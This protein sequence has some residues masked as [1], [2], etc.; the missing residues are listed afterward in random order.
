MSNPP[1]QCL[2][3]D[4]SRFVRTTEL[5]QQIRPA[6]QD[7]QILRCRRC[8]LAQLHPLPTADEVAAVYENSDYVHAYDAAGEQFVLSGDDAS[9]VLA[10]RFETLATLLP[11]Q[12]RILDVGAS[13]G[14]FLAEAKTRGWEISGLEAGA[15]AI[16]FAR[17]EFGVEIDQGTIEEANYPSNHFD[18]VHISHVLEHVRDPRLA[19]TRMHLWLR[20][21]GVLVVEVPYE[22]GDLFDR[23]RRWLLRRPPSP[24]I[25]P[26]T[27]LYFF[28]LKS[29]SLLL[30]QCG[31]QVLKT[32]TP[33]R[34]QSYDSRLPLGGLI[35]RGVYALE[36]RS[37]LGPNL[38]VFARKT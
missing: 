7:R 23:A 20:P 4:G 6:F 33:R 30:G 29:L 3:C 35:K 1:L 8:G 13:R 10:P 31:F 9:R 26:S 36:Q 32:A 24:N 19:F 34:N 22:F 17:S 21:E 15:D 11:D 37:K 12:G 25:V 14:W 28:T 38:E 18:A 5:E 27:H 2:A 16:E